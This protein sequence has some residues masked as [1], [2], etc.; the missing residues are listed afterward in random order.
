MTKEFKSKDG[1]KLGKFASDLYKE[2]TGQQTSYY[3]VN[4][5]EKYISIKIEEQHL[6][7]SQLKDFDKRMKESIWKDRYIHVVNRTCHPRGW[8]TSPKVLV[9]FTK[10]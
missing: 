9:R 10:L 8:L 7:E 1:S 6:T 5:T 3:Y 2:I 4:L